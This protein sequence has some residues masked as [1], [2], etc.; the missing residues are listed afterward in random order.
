MI[1]DPARQRA[2]D[3]FRLQCN[4]LAWQGRP[5]FTDET[6]AT[7]ESALKA[8]QLSDEQWKWLLVSME[9][10]AGT[11]ERAGMGGH[12]ARAIAT[13]IRASRGEK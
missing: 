2:L 4:A 3:E 12:Q 10:T 9:W 6:R 8:P 5:P 7:I 1:P 13:T 11:W